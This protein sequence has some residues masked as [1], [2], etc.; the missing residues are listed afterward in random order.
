MPDV[1]AERGPVYVMN[2]NAPFVYFDAVPA[3]GTLNGAI[4]I[5]CVA[6][7]MLPTGPAGEMQIDMVCTAHIRCSPTAALELI[8]A[9]Q[10]SLEMMQQPPGPPTGAAVN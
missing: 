5:D 10:K 6:R 9:L 1:A 7:T 8:S 4:Q 3:F 2:P